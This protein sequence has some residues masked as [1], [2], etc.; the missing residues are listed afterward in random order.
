G[1]GQSDGRVVIGRQALRSRDVAPDLLER[2]QQERACRSEPRFGLRDLRLD[3][4]VVAQRALGATRDLV[5]GELDKSVQSASRYAERDPAEAGGIHVAAA[6]SVEE[7][8]LTKLRLGFAQNRVA[9]RHEEIGDGVA[10]ASRAAQTN[11]MPDVGKFG[12]GFPEE[13][14][15][16]HRTAVRPPLR[17]PILA[18]Y[19]HMGAEPGGMMAAAGE[20][21][22]AGQPIA[23]RNR[24]A[25]GRTRRTP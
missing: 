23:A 3:D 8:G 16:H 6:E 1:R 10:V 2:A 25:L 11:D 24:A 4:I 19:R 15:S 13:Q 22:G 7:A 21:P 18:E 9:F 14:G 20:A 12:A 5:A 17:A